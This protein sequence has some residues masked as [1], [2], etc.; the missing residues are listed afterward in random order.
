MI[1]SASGA[2]ITRTARLRFTESTLSGSKGKRVY[3]FAGGVLKART[4]DFN[5]SD[6]SSI[7]SSNVTWEELVGDW[8]I[9]SNRLA[10]SASPT[11]NPIAVVKANT[12]NAQVQI[13]QGGAGFG[14]GVSFWVVDQNNWYVAVTEQQTTTSYSCPTNTSVV[15]LVGTTCTYP[16]SYAATAN[17]C[18]SGAGCWAGG[19]LI[20]GVCGEWCPQGG[21]YSGGICIYDCGPGYGGGSVGPCECKQNGIN[22]GNVIGGAVQCYYG[23][24]EYMPYS[25]SYTCYSCP[26]NSSIV[27]LSGSNC[28]YPANYAATLNTAY[29][30]RMVVKRSIS[31][32]VTTIATSP[33]VS[34][35]S[36]TARPTYVRATTVGDIVTITAPM[37]NESG[38]LTV[39]YNA[40]NENKGKKH[41]VALSS[42]TGTATTSVDNF[43]YS[44]L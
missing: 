41:G 33:S 24:S 42:T 26:T 27:S 30:N 11:T 22:T 6:S 43:E 39:T 15:T 19:T 38:T 28:V 14:W 16:S 20:N 3:V 35:T 37:D 9:S 32:S 5:R 18:T 17:T 44:P 2:S 23:S 34:T 12:R 25:F 29:N 13:G 31:G 8:E 4:D 40:L 7:S 36:S 10:T 1:Y 21:A